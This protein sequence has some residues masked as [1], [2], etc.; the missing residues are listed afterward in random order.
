[1]LNYHKEALQDKKPA[2]IMVWWKSK[3]YSVV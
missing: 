2:W 3:L 1:M